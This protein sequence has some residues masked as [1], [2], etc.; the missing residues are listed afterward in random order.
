MERSALD[1]AAGSFDPLPSPTVENVRLSKSNPL[2]SVR[3]AFPAGPALASPIDGGGIESGNNR[4][5]EQ[6]VS[7]N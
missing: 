3:R 4:F 1:A 5:V 2:K 6:L 7:Q